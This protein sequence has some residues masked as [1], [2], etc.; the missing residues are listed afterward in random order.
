MLIDIFTY[1]ASTAHG[2]FGVEE[3]IEAARRAHLDGIGITDRATSSRSREYVETARR[4]GY[5]V[6]VGLEL[7]TDIGRVTAY[8]AQ[9]D[10]EYVSESWRSL[11]ECP[12]AESVLDYF[13]QRGGIVVAR[14]VYNRDEGMKD[15][16]YSAKDSRGRGFDCVDTLAVYRRRIDN[17]LSIEAQ[18]VMGVGGC[19]GSGVFDDLS[20]IG[21]C[22]TLFADQVIDQASFVAAMRGVLHWAVGLRDLGQACPMGVPPRYDEAVEER[23]L[24]SD[25]GSRRPR[26]GGD[27]RRDGRNR[28]RDD[29]RRDRR[30]DGSDNRRGERGQ[31]R[32][33]GNGGRR[34]PQG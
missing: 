33:S 2:V 18:K 14:D 32:R 11:G 29:R 24:R 9:V 6:I 26:R 25:E 23:S 15:R 4:L 20:D 34:R 19:A 12:T 27:D 10:D 1:S 16:V 17:E 13:H 31:G 22:A 28:G 21:Y 5:L 8:P 30:D 3:L 7:E